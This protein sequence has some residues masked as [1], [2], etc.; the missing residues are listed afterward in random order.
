MQKTIILALLSLPLVPLTQGCLAAVG[1]GAGLV[2]SQDLLDN[3]T[4][5]TRL[6]TDVRRVWPTVKTTLSGASLELIEVDEELRVA[7]AKV[8]G[9]NVTVS[10]EAFDIDKSIL[11]VTARKFGMNDGELARLMHDKIVRD[12]EH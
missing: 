2:L 5:V 3:N 8:D 1:V 4:Y 9:A 6:N 11:R 7:R 10:V 12:L